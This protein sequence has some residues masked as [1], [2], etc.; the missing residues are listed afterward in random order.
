MTNEPSN[1]WRSEGRKL[2][3]LLAVFLLCVFL[4]VGNV[5]F[6]AALAEG[7]S[8]VR[9]YARGNVLFLLIPAFFMAGAIE[10]FVSKA[11]IVKYFGAKTRKPLSYGVASVSGSILTVCSCTVLPLFAGI[12]R[13]GAGLGPATTF[14][15][16]GPA[17][18]LLAILLTARVLGPRLGVA[19]AVG[20]VFFSV[21]IGLAM[22]ALHGNRETERD[23]G[24]D[25]TERFA[26]QQT[27]WGRTAALVGA[28]AAV[29]I[30]ANWARTGDVRAVFLCCPAGLATAQVEGRIVAESEYEVVLAGA[31]GFR[32]AI[33]AQ[34]IVALEPVTPSVWRDSLYR[35]RWAGVAAALWALLFILMR[36]FAPDERKAWAL[37]SWG[38]AKRILPLLLAGVFLAGFLNGRPGHDGLIPSRFIEMLLGASP[39]PALAALG[40]DT[41][42]LAAFVRTVWPV[43]VNLFAA[44]LG[45]FMYFATLTEIPIL[46]GLLGAGMGNGPALALLLAGPA[47]SLPSLLV[48]GSVLG[49]RR[50][51]SFAVLVIVMATASG[52][53]YGGIFG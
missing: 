48:I 21:V 37:G 43:W 18:N 34:Q 6:H 51:L 26:S 17:I 23:I 14:L 31:D 41:G 25:P 5:R 50:T 44:V 28:L 53:L 39:E 52:L 35:L 1:R 30:F 40:R 12:C 10:S 15:Y 38:F 36:L 3:L 20:A 22:H 11:A 8:L 2:A 24:D 29:L 42:A 49:P 19:R 45:V 32:H 33:P 46:Q 4:P 9:W 47:L 16:S 27:L 13:K 7:L